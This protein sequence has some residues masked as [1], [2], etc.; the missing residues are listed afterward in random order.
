MSNCFTHRLPIFYFI[1]FFAR[2]KQPKMEISSSRFSWSHIFPFL[3]WLPTL[4]RRIIQGDLLAGITGAIIV[5]PQ[6]VAYAII[7]GLPPE[8]GLY[9]AIVPAIVAA[10]FGSSYHLISGPTVA[11]S[12]VIFTTLNPLAEIGSQHYI[13]LALTMTLLAG[14]FQLGLGLARLGTLVNFV[15]HSVVIAF[16]AG[17]AVIIVTSQMKHILGLTIPSGESFLYTWH[18]IIVAATHTNFWVFTIAMTTLVSALLF[19]RLFPKLPNMLLAMIV[20]SILTLIIGAEE[21]HIRLV[22]SLPAHLPP[23]SIPDLSIAT[24]HALAPSALALALL[25][26]VEAVSIARAVAIRSHQHID[27]NQEFIG[28]GLSNVVGSFFSCYASSGSFTRTGVNYEAGAKTP[29]AAIFAAISLALIVLLIA[30][31]TA[32]VPIPSMAGIL[33]VVS[34]NLID[35]HHIKNIIKTSRSETAILLV[36]FL[37]TLFMELEFAIYIGVLLSLTIYLNRT[38]KPR[39]ISL[40][41][42]SD[43]NRHR[44]INVS[45][46]DLPECPQL[47]II[48]LDG[49]L[50]FGAVSYT[51]KKL[52]NITEPHLLIV[53]SGVNFIDVAG[54][55]MVTHEIQRRRSIDGGLYLTSI[56]NRAWEIF[57]RGEYDEIIRDDNIF[58][59]KAEAIQGV[60]NRLDK[61]IC[62]QCRVR[63]FHECQSIKQ[64]IP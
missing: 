36:T 34:Y 4:N 46:K 43:D 28:Q 19:K 52:Q 61:E 45:K 37:S 62:K 60:F 53:C 54:A 27:G 63:I 20:G 22:G 44:L 31:L 24:F 1:Y 39:F 9:A 35:F 38:S 14:A 56:K 47:K 29:L 16:T 30:P 55:E 13:N 7:A 40:A 41:P 33:L 8:Y 17:A 51:T 26:L 50:F 42:D 49:S 5:L 3:L 64:I 58:E 12:I 32:Y 25:G 23:I 2:Q 15:S 11:M 18:E 6:G 48:R 21:H 57:Q 10:L 59:T